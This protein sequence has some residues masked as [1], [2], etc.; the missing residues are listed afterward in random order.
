VAPPPEASAPKLQ[1]LKELLLPADG[2]YAAVGG[3]AA[4]ASPSRQTLLP[5]PTWVAAAGGVLALAAAA[6]GVHWLKWPRAIS[7]RA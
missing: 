2:E 7:V 3:A 4:A 6:A 1:L 5:L